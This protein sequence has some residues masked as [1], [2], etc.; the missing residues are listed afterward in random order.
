MYI[1]IQ[2]KRKNGLSGFGDDGIISLVFRSNEYAFWDLGGKRN[3]ERI[4]NM[5]KAPWP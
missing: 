1:T 2:M 5:D 4:T 3:E